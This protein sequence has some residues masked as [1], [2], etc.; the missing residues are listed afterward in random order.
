MY[1]IAPWA[2]HAQDAAIMARTKGDTAKRTIRESEMTGLKYFDKLAP[3]LERLHGDGCARDK[4][5]NR[6]LH[7][8]QYCLLVLLSLRGAQ[9]RRGYTHPYSTVYTYQR[10]STTVPN[11]IGP[12]R[13]VPVSRR[14][15]LAFL[16]TANVENLVC[17]RRF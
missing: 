2:H 1:G 13:P 16:C 10:P 8:D 12:V 14:R 15:V 11:S 5:G 6:T 4:A 9:S 3:L 7:F 17:V